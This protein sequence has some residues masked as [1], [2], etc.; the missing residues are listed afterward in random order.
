MPFQRR[1]QIPVKRAHIILRDA[2]AKGVHHANQF[3]RIRI[4]RARECF[5]QR[6][7]GV[8]LPGLHQIAGLFHIRKDRERGQKR[9]KQKLFHGSILT[10]G[11][12]PM[13]AVTGALSVADFPPVDQD[14]A[15]LGQLLFY[16]KILSGNQNISCATCH[17]PSH[18][19]GDGLSLGVGEGGVGLG[20]K[21]T[22]GTG[23]D[24][25]ERRVPRNAP[26]LWNLGADSVNILMHDGRIS[27]SD[28]YGNGFNTPAEEWLPDGLDSLLAVQ[29]LFPLTSEVE[30]RGDPEENEVAGAVNQ[31]LD[32]GWPIIAKRVR[33]I[34]EYGA[35]F[36]AAFEHINSPEEV[37]IVEIANAIGAFVALE[38]RS[39][40]S[41]YDRA[42]A[43]DNTALTQLQKRGQDL[44]FGKADCASCHTGPLLSDQKFHAM[45]VPPIG[46]GR[47]RKFDLIS[48][49]VGRMGKTNLVEDAY[50]FR[51]PSLRNVAL[52]APYGHNGA[53]PTLDAF[54]RHH[55]NPT[56]GFDTFVPDTLPLPAAAWLHEDDKAIWQNA[57]EIA[58]QRAA[59]LPVKLDLTPA[60]LAEIEAFLG[61]LTGD[62]VN[63]LR[64]GVPDRVPSGLP[65][66][67]GN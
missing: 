14:K 36:V 58:R 11:L 44:F 67:Q 64:F 61:A 9:G 5:K 31:R 47:T 35:G 24:R 17:H 6:A 12:W 46:P 57:Q 48:R 33:T 60:E 8:K 22:T 50:K 2:K 45:G 52:T 26:A 37:S 49:D 63:N 20:P 53:Y 27:V 59:I 18:G 4:A 15:A 10:L 19:G 28:S 29:A 43:G 51:T 3:L 42:L 54:L 56:I 41:P 34:P 13:T 23:I 30:M 25:I 1:P 32:Y 39:F 38:F 7:C 55:V 16:D 62:S 40:D 66:D 21:R 65:V